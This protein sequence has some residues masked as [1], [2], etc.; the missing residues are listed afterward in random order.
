LL[1][2]LKVEEKSGYGGGDF[3]HVR[4]EKKEGKK[5]IYL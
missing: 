1:G 5:K 4:E 2:W 3:D